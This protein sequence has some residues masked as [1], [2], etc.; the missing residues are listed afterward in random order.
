MSNDLWLRLGE[1]QG[2]GKIARMFAER[3]EKNS[4]N[5]GLRPKVDP[6]RER[7]VKALHLVWTVV[8]WVCAR[9]TPRILCHTYLYGSV[10][11]K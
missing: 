8:L 11:A 3:L 4:E 7:L 9:F 6:R 1:G 2:K 10:R 5:W